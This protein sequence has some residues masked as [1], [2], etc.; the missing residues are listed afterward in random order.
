M[1]V[2]P[3]MIVTALVETATGLL[4][5][6]WPALVFVLL[7]GWRQAAPETL[8]IGRLAGA[9]VIGIG[10]ASWPARH[11]TRTP[12]QLGV[13]AGLLAYNVLAALLL[14]FAG[15]QDCGW[16]ASSSGPPSCIMPRLPPGVLSACRAVGQPGVCERPD[17]PGLAA[18]GL[19]ARPPRTATRITRCDEWSAGR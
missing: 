17:G 8:L 15:A 10:V 3:L 6:V 12:A 7:L 13:L 14:A 2:T 4:L 19:A 16:W 11:D 5:L 1:R 9:A 18:A